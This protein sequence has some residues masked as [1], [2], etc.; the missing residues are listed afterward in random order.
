MEA[1]CAV[2]GFTK[3]PS[4]LS[5]PIFLKQEGAESPCGN[6]PNMPKTASQVPFNMLPQLVTV[7]FRRPCT[8]DDV[9]CREYC[10]CRARLRH[11]I[12][13]PVG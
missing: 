3:K 10:F 8:S 7:L 12:Q 4:N 6:L 1:V 5:S 2:A 13:V 9:E 11:L